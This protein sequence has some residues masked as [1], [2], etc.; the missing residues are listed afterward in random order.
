MQLIH[1]NLYKPV[2]LFHT[3]ANV[4]KPM[5]LIH[6]NVYEPVPLIFTVEQSAIILYCSIS[7]SG[8]IIIKASVHD[9]T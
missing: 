6:I 9:G 7:K 1:T 2:H 3:N 8:Q 4:Y 5:H